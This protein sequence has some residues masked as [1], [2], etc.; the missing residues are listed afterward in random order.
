MNREFMLMKEL[1]GL[2]NIVDSVSEAI[3]R[4]ISWLAVAM[5][6]LQFVLVVMRYVFGLASIFM[7]E[8]VIYM[9]GVLFM[10]A[11]GY[12][13][14]HDGHVRVDVFYREASDR[15]RA[16]VNLLGVFGLL[17][18]VCLLIWYVSWS[19]VAQSW[20]VH[21]GSRE[22]SGIQGVFLLKS[23]IL[24]FVVLMILQGLSLAARAAIVLMGGPSPA[25]QRRNGGSI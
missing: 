20:S 24:V 9:H 25:E 7:Q 18:P 14:L 8:S 5:V 3:G 1:A 16:W 11:A 19:Y 17:I 15:A 4:T 21:E 12:T 6:L 13:L 23:V 22:T 10:V 2:A